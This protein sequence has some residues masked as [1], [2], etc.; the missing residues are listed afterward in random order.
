V[1][2]CHR[3]ARYARSSAAV[4]ESDDPIPDLP[5]GVYRHYKGGLYEVLGAARHSEDN[6]HFAVYRPLPPTPYQPGLRVRPLEMF[7]ETVRVGD[8]DVRRF[9][10]VVHQPQARGDEAR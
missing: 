10:R 3:S 8:R 4:P 6:T 2:C 7:R 1:S 9:E 5:A